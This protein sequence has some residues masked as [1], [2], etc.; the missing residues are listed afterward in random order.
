MKV[1]A[2]SLERFLVEERE[3]TLARSLA[4]KAARLAEQELALVELEIA[5]SRRTAAERKALVAAFSERRA[6]AERDTAEAL[7]VF[8]RR[9]DLLFGRYGERAAAAWTDEARPAL[10]RRVEEIRRHVRGR[11]RSDVWKDLLQAGR[12]AVDGFLEGFVPVESD[13]LRSGYERLRDEVADAAARRAEAVWRAAADLLPIQ[14]PRVDPPPTPPMPRPAGLQLEP[15]R[16]ML[17]DLEDTVAALLPRGMALRRLA[18]R[19]LVEADDRYGQAVE[20][21]LE[22]FV[23]AYEADFRSLL[24]L[25]EKA[26]GET[27]AALETALRAAE[28]RTREAGSAGLADAQSARRGALLSLLASLRDVGG[29]A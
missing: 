1:L 20:Q 5:A 4:R 21:T 2:E 17:E 15:L 13:R 12:A 7:L 9:F 6:T 28:T 19:A 11:A 3:E 27:A 22:G 23:R 18:A 14:P 29:T 24:A 10:A 26:P 16:L 8:R 25:F